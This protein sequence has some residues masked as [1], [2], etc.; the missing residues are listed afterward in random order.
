MNNQ[1][2]MQQRIFAAIFLVIIILFLFIPE[3]SRSHSS[4]YSQQDNKMARWHEGTNYQIGYIVDPGDLGGFLNAQAVQILQQAFNVWNNVPTSS[5]SFYFNGYAPWDID[6]FKSYKKHSVLLAIEAAFNEIKAPEFELPDAPS[7]L[8]VVAFDNKGSIIEEI[9][10]SHEAMLTI[11]GIT[12][13]IWTIDCCGLEERIIMIAFMII[14]DLDEKGIPIKDPNELLKIMTHEAGHFAN[15]GHTQLN[16]ETDSS[17]PFYGGPNP[18]LFP[19]NSAPIM[20]LPQL[21]AVMSMQGGL[22]LDDKIAVSRL[23]PEENFYSDNG[24]LQTLVFEA[25]GPGVI[26]GINGVNVVVRSTNDP[27]HTAASCVTGQWAYGLK[28]NDFTFDLKILLNVLPFFTVH[29]PE[30]DGLCDIPGLPPGEYTVELETTVYPGGFLQGLAPCIPTGEKTCATFDAAPSAA[31]YLG[32]KVV[33]IAAGEIK[34]AEFGVLFTGCCTK[35][36]CKHPITGEEV[37]CSSINWWDLDEDGDF[38][39][40]EGA[41]G[42]LA[43]NEFAKY[44]DEDDDGLTNWAESIL[45]T[46]PTNDDT[47]DDG[48]SDLDEYLLYKSNP[49]EQDTDGDGIADYEEAKTYGTNPNSA[50]S[51]GDGVADSEEILVTKT[52]PN[53]ADSDDDGL[54]DGEEI[55]TNGT[56]PLKADSDGDCW[57]D[58]LEVQYAAHGYDPN[59]KQQSGNLGFS[60]SSLDFGTVNRRGNVLHYT[61][62][63]TGTLPLLILK[64]E[65]LGEGFSMGSLPATIPPNSEVSIPVTF[66]PTSAESASGKITLQTNDCSASLAEIPL[67]AQGLVANLEVSV[68]DIDFKKVDVFEHAKQ[69]ITLKNPASNTPLKVALSNTTNAFWPSPEYLVEVPSDGE[70]KIWINF[71][72]YRF[73]EITDELVIRSFMAANQQEIKINLKGFG[74]GAMPDISFSANELFFAEAETNLQEITVVN[75]GKGDLYIDKIEVVDD[76]EHIISLPEGIESASFVPSHGSLHVPVDSKKK[77]SVKF[78]SQTNEPKKGKLI[79]YHNDVTRNNK[80]EISLS[81]EN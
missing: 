70:K 28:K 38:D 13:P 40:W 52:N 14:N 50:D 72:P 6:A 65:I 75:T 41:Q 60:P 61:L 67:K 11:R 43:S 24:T 35:T 32:K 2:A 78:N 9:T 54:S 45:G 73:G 48:L 59:I 31:V 20:L 76:D 23:Y 7:T 66:H 8:N 51:D 5:I 44:A 17:S 34:K 74:E 19:A 10:G 49:L 22:H 12:T 79:L 53:K 80:S 30:F 21:S 36:T 1:P 25:T 29:T 63:H 46:D 18:F 4:L 69:L 62:K 15:V 3:E 55:K 58:G 42:T 64:G 26:Q 77:I 47:D 57:D 71:K 33:N 39:G 16:V 27:Y 81:G 56:N 68:A 37:E